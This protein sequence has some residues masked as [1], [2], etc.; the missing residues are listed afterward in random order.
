MR[1]NYSRDELLE[2]K[3]PSCPY[4]LFTSWLQQAT[5]TEQPPIEP[6]AMSLATVDEQGRPHCRI[7]L[8]KAL[9]E[10][11]FVFYTNYQSDKGEELEA[12]PAAAITFFW[13]AL[14][15]QVRI[16]GEVEKVSAQES[17]AY[18]AIRPL[19]SRIG[20]LISKQ[21]RML[22]CREQL[23]EQVTV[24]NEIYHNTAPIRPEY[25][26]GYRLLAKRIEF[27]Q[28]QPNRLH[29]RID[30]LLQADGS[31]HRARRYP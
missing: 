17:D 28:G 2:N 13:P 18:F 19:G 3:L 1:R 25:W 30:Y 12:N 20:A 10:R 22:P 16:E 7:M 31:W 4:A 27:W 29:D 21:S 26:G 23:Q 8:L 14:E 6:N 24:A 15:R 5:E 9:D 11:G